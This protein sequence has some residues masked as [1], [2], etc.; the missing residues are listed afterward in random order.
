VP[1]PPLA[2]CLAQN[3]ENNEQKQCA[4]SN[5]SSQ[6]CG[7]AETLVAD[8]FLFGLGSGQ[9]LDRA[10]R[11]FMEPRFGHDFSQVRVHTDSLASDS[12]REIHARAYTAGSDVVF[13]GNQFS[14]STPEGQKL[15][16]HELT[17]VVQ[18]SAGARA[19]QRVPDGP[20]SCPGG[21]MPYEGVCMTDEV[22]EV[23]PDV[24]FNV[25]RAED[26]A[27]AS[28]EVKAARK[29]YVERGK[30]VAPEGA[31]LILPEDW[32]DIRPSPGCS[33]VYPEICAGNATGDY[34]IITIEGYN[35]IFRKLKLFYYRMG[36]DAFHRQIG[37]IGMYR[38]AVWEGT[39]GVLYAGAWAA[40]KA[41]QIG[42][43]LA[44]VP[45]TQI[46]FRGLQKFG[47]E[48]LKELDRME[49]LRLGLEPHQESLLEQM[50]ESLDYL[51]PTGLTPQV[52]PTG[53]KPSR[54]PRG[55][56]G[57]P[58]GRSEPAHLEEQSARTSGG[59]GHEEAPSVQPANSE[60]KVGNETHGVAV[61]GK[62]REAGYE[63]CSE[64][65]MLV[66]KKLQAIRRVLPRAYNPQ[67]VRNLES[68]ENRIKGVEAELKRGAITNKQA[69]RF[70]REI[71]RTLQVYANKDPN[72]SVLLQ[73][74]PKTPLSLG[75]S[76]NKTL[77]RV[78]P[79]PVT[80]RP[81]GRPSEHDVDV[82]AQ[83]GARVQYK[84]YPSAHQHHL[85]PLEEQAWFEERFASVPGVKEDIH[86]YTVYVSEGEHRAIHSTAKGGVV[87]GVKEPDLKGWNKEWKEFKK[88]YGQAS[89][90]QI[91]EHAARLM[92]KYKITQ[93]QIDRYRRAKK[94][95]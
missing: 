89:P 14:P 38:T 4:P 43:V 39:K 31:E 86:D 53:G 87:K 65:C 68:L 71:A 20:G 40:Q 50:E 15:L 48:A 30:R 41:G 16:A 66:R 19:I 77:T 44:K 74:A 69:N 84:A 49:A 23:L 24:N 18:Q 11:E 81:T 9:P 75:E 37:R 34:E 55:K 32:G 90:Q 62:R 91:F 79:D 78:T 5:P 27:R 51:D 70:A 54:A 85:F 6:D 57:V 82:L 10:T 52:H 25:K 33:Y 12:A 46:V 7:N 95:Y 76:G 28:D 58:R 64:K 42:R 35:V 72:I 45:V 56:A 8:E 3:A 93:A 47:T 88:A 13:A 59:V 29:E 60:L 80:A 73:D 17:H 94:S 67:M 1:P 2:Q 92:E 26:L 22:L 63:I 21:A 36:I 61:Y 83:P